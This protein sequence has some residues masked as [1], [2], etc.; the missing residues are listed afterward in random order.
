MKIIILHLPF[1]NY[2]LNKIFQK[3]HAAGFLNKAVSLIGKC[4][5]EIGN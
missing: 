2:F 1:T 4:K 5:L 3:F